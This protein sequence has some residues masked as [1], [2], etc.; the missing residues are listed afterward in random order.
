[1]IASKPL[2]SNGRKRKI[3]FDLLSLSRHGF[4]FRVGAICHP[5]SQILE[6]L[7]KRIFQ[8]VRTCNKEE[9]AFLCSLHQLE[10]PPVTAGKSHLFMAAVLDF[11]VKKA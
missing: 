8:I 2:L 9:E 5:L 6:Q 4:R 7:V 11:A 3:T 1:M 10:V